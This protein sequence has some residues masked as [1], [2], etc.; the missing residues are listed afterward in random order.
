MKWYYDVVDYCSL[1]GIFVPFF[2]NIVKCS[3]SGSGFICGPPSNGS[4]QSYLT[5]KP[6]CWG[7]II[8]QGVSGT[9]FKP[10]PSSLWMK[11]LLYN[12][13]LQGYHLLHH[14]IK[15]HHPLYSEEASDHLIDRPKQ[16]FYD[17]LK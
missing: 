14:V 9:D 2:V 8:F 5:S 11:T 7:K 3:G 13:H 17:D 16:Q 1:F 6:N 4:A 10:L 15:L 12:H